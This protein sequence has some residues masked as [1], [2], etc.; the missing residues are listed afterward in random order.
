[1][2]WI[3]PNNPTGQVLLPER[4]LAWRERLAR[5]GGWLVVDEAFVEGFEGH[6]LAKMVGGDG[7]VVLKSVGKFFGLAGLRAGAVLTNKALAHGFFAELGPWPVS[8]PARFVMT[9]MLEDQQWQAQTQHT[10]T[11]FSERMQNVLSDVGLGS[12]SGTL[13]FQYVEHPKAIELHSGLCR[14]GILVRLFEHPCALRVGLPANE[15]E[16]RRLGQALRNAVE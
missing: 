6:S 9:Q 8:G 3:N 5:C 4:L 16:W 2:V 10:L 13:L 12:S 11:L 7:L 14:Q 1:V 15:P